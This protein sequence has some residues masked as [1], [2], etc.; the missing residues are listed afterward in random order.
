MVDKR[1]PKKAARSSMS[2]P[3]LFVTIGA[4]WS[5]RT[6]IHINTI[7]R[8]WNISIFAPVYVARL[9][10]YKTN[11]IQDKI[12]SCLPI[13]MCA[14]LVIGILVILQEL[15]LGVS[16][17]E[18]TKCLFIRDYR[19]I[20]TISI[21]AFKVKMTDFQIQDD[22]CWDLISLVQTITRQRCLH[23]RFHDIDLC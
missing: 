11:T 20:N 9:F 15:I 5:V 14:D 3:L 8:T 6:R 18:Q 2:W 23:S 19:K 10:P 17:L 16:G 7:L 1:S 21:L 13:F 22:Q 4:D 12:G